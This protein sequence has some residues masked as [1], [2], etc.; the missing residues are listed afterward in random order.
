MMIVAVLMVSCA[1][2]HSGRYQYTSTEIY[3]GL[4]QRVIPIWIDGDFGQADRIAIDDAINKWNYVLNGHILLVVV[5]NNFHMEIDKIKEEE[6]ANGW[7]FLK[8]S[9]NNKSIS[10]PTVD[11]E[12]ALGFANT[13]GGNHMYLV[14]DVL[15]NDQVFGVTLHEIGHLLGSKHTDEGL[16]F[17]YYSQIGNQCIDYNTVVNVAKYQRL[18][19]RDFNYCV[20]KEA[21]ED[22]QLK[23]ISRP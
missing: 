8:I 5:D 2:F 3:T 16:M 21:S 17:P 1:S 23:R 12:W 10:V 22:Y 11:G 4:P 7:L 6:K 18:P 9:K 15:E 13:I 20:A 19:V 14:R